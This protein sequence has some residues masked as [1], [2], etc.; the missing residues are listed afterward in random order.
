MFR[1]QLQ[2][3]LAE[4]ERLNKQSATS[5]ESVTLDQSRMGRLSRM[6]AMQNQ[7]MAAETARRRTIEIQRVKSAL[8]RIDNGAFGYCIQCDEE[9]SPKRLEHNPAAP[10]CIHCAR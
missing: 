8:L 4:L 2:R 7:Q 1:E 3:R 10:T 6:D 9:I 5:R